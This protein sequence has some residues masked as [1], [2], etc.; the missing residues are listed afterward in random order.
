MDRR[1]TGSC[2]LRLA[3]VPVQA[4]SVPMT[5]RFGIASQRYAHG[6]RSHVP[7]LTPKCRM[8]ILGHSWT[9]RKSGLCPAKP[10]GSEP[11]KGCSTENASILIVM[12]IPTQI[13]ARH[14]LRHTLKNTSVD[15]TKTRKRGIFGRSL[16]NPSPLPSWATCYAEVHC[17]LK[18]GYQFEVF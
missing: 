8:R 17:R 10:E 18:L 11:T 7:L 6:F 2:P 1:R 16:I 4:P 13:S 9:R 5:V 12:L 15:Y 3:L 14:I